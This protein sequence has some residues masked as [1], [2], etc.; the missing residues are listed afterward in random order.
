MT[1]PFNIS[2][3]MILIIVTIIF[4]QQK[5]V[6][7]SFDFDSD[8]LTKPILLRTIHD[9]YKR[10]SNVT[11]LLE[12]T[13]YF[14]F[15]VFILRKTR[16]VFQQSEKTDKNIIDYMIVLNTLQKFNL[17]QE[18]YKPIN[19]SSDKEFQDQYPTIYPDTVSDQVKFQ[20]FESFFMFPKK[21][22]SGNKWEKT[23]IPWR[24][25]LAAITKFWNCYY[26]NQTILTL[27]QLQIFDEEFLQPFTLLYYCMLEIDKSHLVLLSMLEETKK[28]SANSIIHLFAFLLGVISLSSDFRL[29]SFE[30]QINILD[31]LIQQ[32][33]YDR[34]SRKK[35]LF[36]FQ[37]QQERAKIL[38]RIVLTSNSIDYESIFESLIDIDSKNIILNQ[39]SFSE[40]ILYDKDEYAN[41]LISISFYYEKMTQPFNISLFMILIIVT[42]M[43]QQQKDVQCSFDFDSDKLTKPIVLQT[44][45]DYYKRFSNVTFLLEETNY[46]RFAVFILRKTRKMFQQSEKTD[47]NII[48]YMIV[49]NTMQKFNLIQENYKPINI[50]SDKEFQD[51]YPTIYPDTVSDQVKFQAFESFFMFPKKVPSGNKWEKTIIP[52]QVRLAAITKF[53]NCYYQNQ[54]ILTLQQLQIFDEEFLQPFTLLYYCMLEIDK[55]HLVLLAMLEETKKNSAN[56]IIHLFAFLLGV[57]SLSSDFRLQSFERQMNILD[58]L[59]QQLEYDRTSGKKYL[60]PFQTQQERAKILERIVLTSNSIDYESIFESLIDIDSKNIILNQVSFSEIILFNSISK[61]LDVETVANGEFKEFSEEIG[62]ISFNYDELFQTRIQWTYR[63]LFGT[64]AYWLSSPI[65]IFCESFDEYIARKYVYLIYSEFFEIFLKYKKFQYKFVL[66]NKTQ[67][68]FKSSKLLIKNNPFIFTIIVALIL[69]FSSIFG[70]YIHYSTLNHQVLASH[71]SVERNILQPDKFGHF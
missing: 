34:K 6:Q 61:K 11:F 21:V 57:I 43:F 69:T 58:N 30:R 17:I 28:N 48:D 67:S 20:A 42:I 14:R 5:D 16:K 66:T 49:L 35:Y 52:W 54:T 13:N 31:N 10:F 29:Q 39:V 70:F 1:Q 22:P 59:I 65:S 56:S 45:H 60:F 64:M 19:I 2:L 26:Q 9:Y 7:C 24:E 23:I 4:Q 15:A 27:Q 3:F 71:L 68:M 47:K 53:W 33:E 25:R 37:T 55:S 50:S 12:E 51:Q 38:E 32:L 40:I 18:N 46:F 8:K 44:I 62:T 63:L 36:P 41:I